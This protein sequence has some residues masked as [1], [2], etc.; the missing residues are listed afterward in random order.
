[1]ANPVVEWAK[2]NPLLAAG[3][4]LG[5]VVVV[6]LVAGGG[7][8]PDEASGGMGAAGVQAYYAAVANQ[9]QAGAV[10]QTTQIRANAET[11]RALIAATY[12]LEAT[13][14]NAASDQAATAAQVQIAQIGSTTQLGLGAM[15]RDVAFKRVEA[16]IANNRGQVEL[17]QLNATMFAQDLAN[18]SQI[19]TLAKSSR[20]GKAQRGAVL[21]AAITGQV[22]PVTYK[23]VNPG[24]SAAGIINAGANFLQSVPNVL[25]IF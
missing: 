15:Q 2:D 24:N 25:G 1:M 5:V 18:R 11:N 14:V 6:M 23:P 12:G 9:A 10:I 19:A 13:K 21:Q 20:L 4:A 16:D 7:D 8:A 17:A 3:A 22:V